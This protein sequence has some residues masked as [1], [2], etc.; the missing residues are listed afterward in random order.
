MQDAWNTYV[1]PHLAPVEHLVQQA[2]EVIISHVPIIVPIVIGIVAAATI[3]GF[4]Y[5]VWQFT[6]TDPNWTN[7][8]ASEGVGH[9]RW[10]WKTKTGW[11]GIGTSKGHIEKNHVNISDKG[12]QKRA[13][14]LKE[15]IAT[16]FYTQDLA[17]WTVDYAMNHMT[18]AQKM[19][20][21]W[22]RTNP[23]GRFATLTL[24]GTTGTSIGYGYRYNN[25]VLTRLDNL[26]SYKV[27]IGIDFA[28]GQPF[29]ITAFPTP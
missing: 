1:A 29:I 20:L 22:M 4:A 9:S 7:V 16:A 26:H 13:K 14:K 23:L 24:T 17:Q 2:Q 28:T 25:G 3:G 5:A 8:S 6:H 18:L 19:Q 10:K 21:L 12:L 15:H 27:V 11:P